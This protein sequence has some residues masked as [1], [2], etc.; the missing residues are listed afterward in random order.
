MII[1]ILYFATHN[2][3][4]YR[5]VTAASSKER[6]ISMYYMSPE[7]RRYTIHIIGSEEDGE[8]I[9]RKEEKKEGEEGERKASVKKEEEDLNLIKPLDPSTIL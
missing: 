5:G 1:K 3:S 9:R 7:E 6:K 4:K 2:E 8:G